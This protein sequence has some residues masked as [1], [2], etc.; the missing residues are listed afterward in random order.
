EPERQGHDGQ[1]YTLHAVPPHVCDVPRGAPAG[2]SAGPGAWTSRDLAGEAPSRAH[3]PGPQ[4]RRVDP[5]GRPG[6]PPIK[7]IRRW[8]G[9]AAIAR[10]FAGSL[11]E[12]RAAR[13]G[14]GNADDALLP[15]MAME[16]PG[17]PT[18]A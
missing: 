16:L 10:C 4:P 14:E 17:G 12:R 13:P 9:Y 2:A 6:Q 3:N 18:G 8:S 15:T 7:R 11:S 1:Q 5:G